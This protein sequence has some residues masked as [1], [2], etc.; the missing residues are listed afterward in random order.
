[1]DL[2]IYSLITYY[3]MSQEFNT[4]IS[5]LIEQRSM[6]RKDLLIG[7]VNAVEK[8]KSGRPPVVLSF[9]RMKKDF[10]IHSLDND[11][12]EGHTIV[13]Y[14]IEYIDHSVKDLVGNSTTS[15]DKKIK[16]YD[17]NDKNN[18]IYMH[19]NSDYSR[20][21]IDG[22]CQNQTKADG[23]YWFKN[24]GNIDYIADTNVW[25]AKN[26]QDSEANYYSKLIS[27]LNTLNRIQFKNGAV[28]DGIVVCGMNILEPQNSGVIAYFDGLLG[29]GTPNGFG[30]AFKG[31]V[32]EITVLPDPSGENKKLDYRYEFR[33]VSL[34]AA[35]EN[36]ESVVFSEN[37]S[38]ELTGSGRY[39]LAATYNEGCYSSDWYYYEISGSTPGRICLSQNDDGYTVISGDELKNI[40]LTLRGNSSE[41]SERFSTEYPSVLVTEKNQTLFLLADSDEDGTYETRIK[42]VTAK[43]GRSIAGSTVKAVVVVVIILI[44][45]AA[46]L[47]VILASRE[48]PH[49]HE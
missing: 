2:N 6:S 5:T 17:P 18:P 16:I 4:C 7:L 1:M 35:A 48:K 27:N 39:S 15:Y 11:Y 20:W 44:A 24:E 22:Y 14:D 29:A 45:A 9:F 28:S 30:Y 31:G 26:Y 38:V 3:H 47:T 34:S 25:D 43:R 46:C 32:D 42:T 13:A 23:L 37:R 8:V 41:L 33:D 19:I 40:T 10:D 49:K 21:L 12:S 36:A